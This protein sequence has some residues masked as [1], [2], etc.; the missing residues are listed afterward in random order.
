VLYELTPNAH[1]WPHS[2]NAGIRCSPNYIYLVINHI[3]TNSGGLDF[4]NHCTF[5]E[6]YFTIYD[7]PISRIEFV[8]TSTTYTTTN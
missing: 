4:I 7:T 1:I 3:G 5:L 8:A 6:C 2:L